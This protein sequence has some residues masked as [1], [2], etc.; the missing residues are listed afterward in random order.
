LD[1][2]VEI[3]D[4]I[5]SRPGE[6]GTL[7]SGRG[8]RVE[9]WR[10]QRGAGSTCIGA[11]GDELVMGA[12]WQ[13]PRGTRE[14][15]ADRGLTAAA[16]AEVSH[17]IAT[18]AK[19]MPAPERDERAGCGMPRPRNRADVVIAPPSVGALSTGVAAIQLGTSR[20]ARA[21]R[22]AVA[23]GAPPWLDDVVGEVGQRSRGQALAHG[24]ILNEGCHAQGRLSQA[25][26]RHDRFSD[27]M[28]DARQRHDRSCDQRAPAGAFSRISR[29]VSGELFASTPTSRIVSRRCHN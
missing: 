27:H 1:P 2:L 24:S 28:G 20:T 16:I 4:A 19:C 23:H 3:V 5:G 17:E 14:R 8:E 12:M 10:N 9:R 15:P 6:C 18:G 29:N 21:M 22:R 11:G 25:R 26:K 13:Q 7:G